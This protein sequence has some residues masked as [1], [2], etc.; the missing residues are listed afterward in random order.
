MTKDVLVTVSGLQFGDGAS[1]EELD[2]IETICPGQFFE[3]K[4]SKYVVYDEM[5]EEI[6]IPI[7][8]RIKIK[9][10]EITVTKKGPFQVQMVFEAGKKTMTEYSTPYGRIM[11]GMD[12][13]K[14]NV[15]E[16]EDEMNV[17]IKYALEANYQF[18]ADCEIKINI[19]SKKETP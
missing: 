2:Q 14:L 4:D 6:D 17:Y 11:L 19:K 9:E 13:E 1:D 18:V 10:D 15:E 8:T 12:T 5:I 7:T 16:S 3:P